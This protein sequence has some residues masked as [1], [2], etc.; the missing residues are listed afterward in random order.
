MMALVKRKM[1]RSIIATIEAIHNIK[2]GNS[3]LY[4][5]EAIDS[6]LPSW[7]APY[8]KPV[9]LHHKDTDGKTIGRVIGA[10]KRE[11]VVCKGLFALVL[12]CKISDLKAKN[13]IKDGRYFTTSVGVSGTNV[14]CSI[15]GHK[16]SSGTLCQHKQGNFYKGQQC[17]WIVKEM[18]AKEISFVIVPSDQYSQIISYYEEGNETNPIILKESLLTQIPLIENTLI[19]KKK[20]CPGMNEEELKVALTEAQ[21]KIATLEANKVV[22][23]TENEQLQT[24]LTEAKTTLTNEVSLREGLE[25]EL[26]TLK[27]IE[28]TNTIE[29]ILTLRE[30]LGMRII[31]KEVLENKT[32]VSLVE[33]L[34]DL[35]AEVVFRESLTPPA[36]PEP[37]NKPEDITLLKNTHVTNTQIVLKEQQQ[38]TAVDALS[39]VAQILN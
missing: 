18:T 25:S 7:T 15:C 31:E 13:G 14:E 1:N 23:T 34:E 33:S 2:T 35:Q 17:V 26:L 16:I 24:S 22:L 39:V 9:I 21:T 36:D 32:V 5:E 38:V 37:S 6:I 27:A 4:T 19:I 12:I 10:E 8:N 30:S 11:S 29:K 3:I 20:G 28:K